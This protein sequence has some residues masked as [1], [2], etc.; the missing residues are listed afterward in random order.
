M[1]ALKPITIPR[2]K[3][4]SAEVFVKRVLA[5]LDEAAA[6]IKSDY[7]KTVRGWK[8]KPNFESKV[9]FS[10]GGYTLSVFPS[11]KN[12]KQYIWV[13]YGTKPH[14]IVPRSAPFL[15]FYAGFK[16]RTRKA[17]IGSGTQKY[18]P[19]KVQAEGV[20]N[21]GIDSRDFSETI[22]AKYQSR[23]KVV[24]EKAMSLSAKHFEE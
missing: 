23:F 13:D 20:Y 4:I 3:I 15:T 11:G 21:P 6:D 14:K 2:N 7:K 1:I 9:L 17:W 22:G 18:F 12:A 19:P 16:P 10:G 5:G 8:R 24:M